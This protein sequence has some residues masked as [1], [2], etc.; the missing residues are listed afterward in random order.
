VDIND[1]GVISDQEF[2]YFIN[3]F[4]G[5]EPEANVLNGL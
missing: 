4:L 1:D 3:I 2:R 5:K